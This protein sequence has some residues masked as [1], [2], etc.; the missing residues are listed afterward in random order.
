MS[1]LKKELSTFGRLRAAY[2][3]LLQAPGQRESRDRLER[4]LAPWSLVLSSARSANPSRAMIRDTLD[5]GVK[6]GLFQESDGVIALSPELPLGLSDPQQGDRHF[7]FGLSHLLFQEG[8]TENQDLAQVIAWFLSQDPREPLKNHH[9]Y[10]RLLKEQGLHDRLPHTDVNFGQFK[11]WACDLGFTWRMGR[12]KDS[13]LI[14]DPTEFIKRALPEILPEADVEVPFGKVL[15]RLAKLCPIFEGGTHRREVEAWAEALARPSNQHLSRSSAMAW[16]RL[17]SLGLISLTR[18]AD[19]E[20]WIL[21]D[22]EQE[23]RYTHLIRIAQNA[24]VA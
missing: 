21:P 22:G 14:P 3:Y 19:T 15:E 4:L 16:L 20:A 23:S 13:W 9:A 12:N 5:E 6:A 1:F 2:R 24:E 7:S 10:E 17:N 8:A 18:H 11:N